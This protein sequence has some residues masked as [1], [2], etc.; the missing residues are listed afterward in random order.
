MPVQAIVTAAHTA[1]MTPSKPITPSVT[2]KKIQPIPK[3][4]AGTKVASDMTPSRDSQDERHCEKARHARSGRPRW[5]TEETSPAAAST[6]A[7][8]STANPKPPLAG[9]SPNGT[10][11]PISSS[12]AKPAPEAVVKNT[13]ESAGC[14]GPPPHPNPLRPQ[15]RL[16]TKR[17]RNKERRAA[18]VRSFLPRVAGEG[19]HAK[20]GG[21]GMRASLGPP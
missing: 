7:V 18:S 15:G 16:C 21:G 17:H 9:S 11:S 13:I 6:K 14:I 12:S 1:A 4:A 2:P 19:D 5:N 3:T 20:H 10:A 8:A